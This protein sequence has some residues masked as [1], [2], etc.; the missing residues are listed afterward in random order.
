[1]ILANKEAFVVS[2]A[3]KVPF[4]SPDI[5]RW[6]L[7]EWVCLSIFLSTRRFIDTMGRI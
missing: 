3:G 4:L 6:R 7:L 1:M 2:I 5:C